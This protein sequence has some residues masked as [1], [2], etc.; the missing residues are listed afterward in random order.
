VSVPSLTIIVP[1]SVVGSAASTT[2]CPSG[3]LTRMRGPDVHGNT[4][5]ATS[6]SSVILNVSLM[7]MLG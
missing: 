1:T 5:R 4:K 2:R 3:A 6:G 7:A